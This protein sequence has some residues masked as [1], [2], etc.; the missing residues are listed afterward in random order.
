[1]ASR[2]K[3][4]RQKERP[5]LPKKRPRQEK[6]APFGDH[7]RRDIEADTPRQGGKKKKKKKLNPVGPGGKR[8]SPSRTAFR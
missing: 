8:R 5:G 2:E 3:V 6:D 4:S 1:M 7:Q